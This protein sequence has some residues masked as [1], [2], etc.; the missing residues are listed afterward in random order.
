MKITKLLTMLIALFTIEFHQ[1]AKAELVVFPK[2]GFQIDP[3]DA[4]TSN[5]TGQ[6]IMMF[7]PSKNSFSANVNVQIQPYGEGIKNY[8]ALTDGQFKQA[9]L[10]IISEKQIG[11]NE[12]VCEYSG[13]L[14]GLSLHWYARGTF[15]ENKVYLVTATALNQDWNEDSIPLKKCVDSFKIK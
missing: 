5:A 3:L 8:I 15:H 11:D 10:N 7:L 4:P 9:G 6:A 14:R 13:D 12:W 2:Y 1:E